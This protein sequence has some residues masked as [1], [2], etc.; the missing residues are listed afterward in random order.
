MLLS[1]WSPSSH[2]AWRPYLGKDRRT[3]LASLPR[4]CEA[5]Q[6]VD[7]GSEALAARLLLAGQWVWITGG[8][9]GRLGSR[10]A[11]LAER[12]VP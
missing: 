4:I 11:E 9:P 7:D 10:S 5:L 1:G 8:D 2:D 12:G 6:A 3:W